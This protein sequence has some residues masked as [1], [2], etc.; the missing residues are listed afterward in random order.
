MNHIAPQ[1]A[2][3]RRG[4][5]GG[6]CR[7]LGRRG[8]GVHLG[9]FRISFGGLRVHL[10]GL[11][12]GG[13]D[14]GG[15]K[16]ALEVVEVRRCKGRNRRP[17]L[18]IPNE[19]LAG[20]QHVRRQFEVHRRIRR[21]Q[22]QDPRQVVG[23]LLDRRHLV[24][25]LVVEH[26]RPEFAGLLEIAGP[27]DGQPAADR[28]DALDER[29]VEDHGSALGQAGPGDRVAGGPQHPVDIDLDVV[30]LEDREMEG[31]SGLRRFAH[32]VL[33]PGFPIP[34]LNVL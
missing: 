9:R 20:P 18:G 27:F 12:I 8:L 34:D 28:H 11:G 14:L 31:E 2:C 15:G 4:S 16:G 32:R 22:P 19:D 10:R 24:V 6:R 5:L 3:Q 26:P 29:R 21:P 13:G 30:F 7:R 17:T 25:E 23:H 1:R 33:F